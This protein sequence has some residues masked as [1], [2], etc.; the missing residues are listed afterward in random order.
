MH[1]ARLS[2]ALNCG[3]A[4]LTVSLMSVSSAGA[5]KGKVLNSF[6]LTNGAS[7]TGPLTFDSSGN[8][9]GTTDAGGV[10]NGCANNGCGIVYELSPSGST[11]TETVLHTFMNGNDGG[12][13]QG[14][15]I[16]DKTGNLYGT[17][18]YA[19]G[20]NGCG[21][22][23]ELVPSGGSWTNNVLHSFNSDLGDGCFPYS[24]LTFDKSGNLYGTTA[25]G[26]TN[27]TGVVFELT[28]NSGGGWNFSVI[29]SFGPAGSGDGVNPFGTLVI[30]GGGNLYGT[31][32]GGG[33]YQAGSVVKLA[34]ANGGW[35]ESVLYNFIGLT[36][37]TNPYAGVIFDSNGNLF[38]TT[39]QG[40]V[41]NVGVIFELTPSNGN[42]TIN[43]LYT[44]TGGPDGGHPASASLLMDAKGNLYGET[45]NGGHGQ[46]G[47]AF[48]LIPPSGG[49]GWTENVLHRFVNSVDGSNPT[50]GLIFDSLGNLYGTDAHGGVGGYGIAFEGTLTAR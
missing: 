13:P 5:V 10:G 37:G 21:T 17:T 8:L 18:L 40:G 12:G 48:Q 32:Y 25:S 36:T 35:T 41:D 39:Y 34:P 2:C 6:N 33:L 15:V 23:F 30:D 49:G 26:G 42:W 20:G 44:F 46:F 9:Y 38:G 50:G 27:D 1:H 47:V 3:V 31:T 24:G 4:L 43:V 28:P 29:Y 45:F 16:F 22:I 11:W 19:G 7:P 14:G